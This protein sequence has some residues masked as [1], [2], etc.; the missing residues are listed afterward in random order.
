MH[1]L[2]GDSISRNGGTAIVV[3]AFHA[4]VLYAIAAGLGVVQAPIQ[5][6]PIKAVM[7]DAVQP[8]RPVDPLPTQPTFEK[9]NIVV[10]P[11]IPQIPPEVPIETA[12]PAEPLLSTAPVETAPPVREVM[13][14]AN[15]RVKSR[16]EPLYPAASRRGGEEGTVVIRLRVDERGRPVEL[17]VVQSTGYNRLDEAALQAVRKWTFWP[18]MRGSEPISVWTTVRVTFRLD[19]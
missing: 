14:I 5:I 1:A 3:V 19:Q 4:L 9:P 11:V 15:L 12:P 2:R 16:T 6:E 13:E 7:I 18:A 17:S 10:D 8:T